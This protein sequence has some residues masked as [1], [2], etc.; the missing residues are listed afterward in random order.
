[1]Q[2]RL[3]RLLPVAEERINELLDLAYELSDD[4]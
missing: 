4:Q 2:A 1:V 3:E